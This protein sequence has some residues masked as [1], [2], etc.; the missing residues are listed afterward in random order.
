MQGFS[1][2]YNCICQRKWIWSDSWW[3]RCLTFVSRPHPPPLP[4]PLNLLPLSTPTSLTFPFLPFYMF[5]FPPTVFLSPFLPVQFFIFFKEVLYSTLL[6]IQ[7]MRK[8]LDFICDTAL[9]PLS[10]IFPVFREK[11]PS[12]ISL[13][14]L[15]YIFSVI[16]SFFF[17]YYCLPYRFYSWIPIPIAQKPE[18]QSLKTKIIRLNSGTETPL[19]GEG[20]AYVA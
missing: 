13:F 1:W 16:K 2:L 15:D 19:Q 14:S 6:Q 20:A 12:N 10:L 11:F 3:E 18:F 17:F 8:R 7:T 4:P 9:L 5:Y